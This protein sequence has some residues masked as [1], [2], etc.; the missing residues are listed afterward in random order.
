MADLLCY[1]KL[2][3]PF[4]M[5]TK[6]IITLRIFCFILT[7]IVPVSCSQI[8]PSRDISTNAPETT[9]FPLNAIDP[10]YQSASASPAATEEPTQ[11]SFPTDVGTLIELLYITDPSLPQY[12][13]KSI[14]YMQFSDILTRLSEM[15]DEAI[16]AASTIAVAISFP[17]QDSYL[18][19]KAL[20]TLGPEITATTL[21]ILIDNLQR[22]TNNSRLYSTL[23]ISSV[24]ESASCAAAEVAELLWDEDP[25]IRVAAAYALEEIT[26]E[27]L[28]SLEIKLTADS[29]FP[30]TIDKD[31]PEGHLSGGARDWWQN[32]GSTVNW[33]PAYGICD[34]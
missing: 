30:L 4:K 31:L 10:I 23:L 5:E 2:C 26:G 16:D 33:H 13:P 28:L 19:A 6:I 20:L 29:Q 15:G 3:Y 8:S 22:K 27:D 7:A 12:N 24:G 11:Q 18:A 34:P 25:Q 21:P 14:A 17:R 9:H 32:T 1:L